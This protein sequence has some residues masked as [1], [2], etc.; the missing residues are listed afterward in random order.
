MPHVSK[1][2]W[3]ELKAYCGAYSFRMVNIGTFGLICAMA[4]RTTGATTAV[5]AELCTRKVKGLAIQRCFG[6]GAWQ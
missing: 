6:K 1:K 4:R 5:S 3:D 2:K